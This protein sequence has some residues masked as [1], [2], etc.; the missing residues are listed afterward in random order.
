MRRSCPRQF[1]QVFCI[2][3]QQKRIE[4]RAVYNHSEHN[5]II[6][7]FFLA[8]RCCHKDGFSNRASLSWKYETEAYISGGCAER[9]EVEKVLF[10]FYHEPRKYETEAYISGD[11]AERLEVE[12][13]LFRFYH[14]PRK[15][16]TEA[17]TSSGFDPFATSKT[18]RA[19]TSCARL[20]LV[21]PRFVIKAKE[22]F[23]TSFFASLIFPHRD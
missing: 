1:L 14:E 9:L 19:A 18:L 22:D 15:Y 6:L 4:M 3:N 20:G 12:K 16:E 21:F 2:Q 17:Y 8:C 5:S 13:V 11:C 7:F 10:R 23:R